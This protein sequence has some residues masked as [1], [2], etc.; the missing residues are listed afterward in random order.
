MSI[1]QTPNMNLPVP[2]VGS[3]D[4]PQYAVDVNSCFTLLDQHDHTPGKGVA[5]TPSGINVNAALSMANNFL[6]NTAG[7]NFQAQG[8]T[9]GLNTIYVNGVDYYLVDGSGNN[10]RLTQSGGIAGA[11][12]SIS[13]LVA[14]ASAT[15][16]P[17]LSTFIWQS[18]TNIAANMDVGALL[19]RNLSPNSTFALTLQPPAGLAANYTITL[20]ASP[21]VTS[22]LTIDNSGTITATPALSGALVASNLSASAGILGSQL[23]ASANIVGPQLSANAGVIPGQLSSMSSSNIGSGTASTGTFSTASGSLVTVTGLDSTP[24]GQGMTF[25]TTRPMV[26]QFNGDTT[27]PASIVVSGSATFQIQL[28]TGTST[29]IVYDWFTIGAGTYSPS[30]LNQI[31]P[32]GNGVNTWSGLTGRVRIQVSTSGSVAVNHVVMTLAQV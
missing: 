18:N 21:G 2:V 7:V 22:F 14:P 17:G 10:I 29:F 13:G 28:F 19:M 5:I 31:L 20:P 30:L 27:T 25:T 23:S 3:E 26:M 9:P 32:L 6:S 15:Y 8:S 16:V 12:G 4:G 1:T 11:P 24:S